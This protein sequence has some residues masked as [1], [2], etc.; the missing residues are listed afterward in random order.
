MARK[1]PQ[2]PRDLLPAGVPLC[3]AR[4]RGLIEAARASSASSAIGAANLFVLAVQEVGKAGFLV[5]AH[6]AGLLKPVVPQFYDHQE[7]TTRG[8]ALLGDRVAW[9]RQGAFDDSFD[10]SFDIGTRTSEAT[11]MELLYVNFGNGAWLS[12]PEIDPVELDAAID[13][14]LDGLPAVERKLVEA[15]S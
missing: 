13:H 2:I 1:G 4:A 5:A 10:S 14:A 3:I 7:K 8:I 12:P 11:R 15:M 6:A 9:L